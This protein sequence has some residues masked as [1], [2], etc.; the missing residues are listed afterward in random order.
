MP[1]TFTLEVHSFNDWPEEYKAEVLTPGESLTDTLCDPWTYVTEA[2]DECHVHARAVARPTAIQH[3]LWHGISGLG[4]EGHHAFGFGFQSPAPLSLA[5]KLRVLLT[6]PFPCIASYCTI[7][8]N[9]HN[10]GATPSL[11]AR[12]IA[13]R[14]LAL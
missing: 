14:R 13:E 1:K 11:A 8:L 9:V 6:H 5:G 3:E 7:R 2:G 4:N 12:L 10:G